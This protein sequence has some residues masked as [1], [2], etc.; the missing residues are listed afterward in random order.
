LAVGSPLTEGNSVMKQITQDY[1]LPDEWEGKSR[2]VTISIYND[3]LGQNVLHG[4][5]QLTERIEGW[6][7]SGE[8]WI[9][10]DAEPVE[11]APSWE[12]DPETDRIRAEAIWRTAKSSSAVEGITKPFD[13]A[14]HDAF[15]TTYLRD[16][17]AVE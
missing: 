13:E 11:P 5:W 6:L 8:L 2:R 16:K 14:H 7:P 10:G 12:V 1:P 9:D 3:D 15:I 4:G 17:A